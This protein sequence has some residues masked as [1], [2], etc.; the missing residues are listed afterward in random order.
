MT[1]LRELMRQS[2]EHDH[3]DMVRLAARARS[4]DTTLRR[5]RRLAA[6]GS[7]VAVVAVV[8]AGLASAGSF[9]PR[10]SGVSVETPVAGQGGA[11][12]PDP[13]G[14]IISSQGRGYEQVAYPAAGEALEAAVA[15][16]LP[17]GVISDVDG[18]RILAEEHIPETVSA[19]LSLAP[20][21]G[22]PAG[23]VSVYFL[24][25]PVFGAGI[26]SEEYVSWCPEE[27]LECEVSTLA[28]GSLVRT[29]T[30]NQVD[31]PTGPWILYDASTGSS[32]AS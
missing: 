26:S 21:A 20:T 23:S 31:T 6:A 27:A 24:T 14:Q 7:S 22:A 15:A 17:D 13:L 10:D 19:D 9:F 11:G 5:R 30:V 4:R 2:V 16:A 29:S 12:I 28:D 25:P 3:A 8:V 1:D 32:T 18:R